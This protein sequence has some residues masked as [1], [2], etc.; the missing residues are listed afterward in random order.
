MIPC[1]RHGSPVSTTASDSFSTAMICSSLNRL[2]RVTPPLTLGRVVNPW[3]VGT[4]FFTAASRILVSTQLN[5]RSKNRGQIRALNYLTQWASQVNYCPDEGLTLDARCVAERRRL[6]WIGAIDLRVGNQMVL[7]SQASRL[8]RRTSPEETETR[9]S[10]EVP[11][12]S[13]SRRHE[14]T[15]L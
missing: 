2:L 12:G 6:L 10:Q 7:R 4:A 9:T 1:R 8:L 14:V 15:G 3:S 13:P 5:A 11:A